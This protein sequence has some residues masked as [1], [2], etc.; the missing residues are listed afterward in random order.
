M[1]QYFELGDETLWNPSNGAAR[2]FLRQVAVFEAELGLPSGIGPMEN[3]ESAIDPA[4]LE[5]FATALLQRR[6]NTH[7]RIM[8]I[9]SEGFTVT[10]LALAEQ[11]HLD[12]PWSTEE[13]D[14]LRQQVRRVR[15]F[16]PT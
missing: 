13:E 10:L 11:A 1:S 4:A 15:G 9:L 8:W 6:R 16:M 2:L 3:D 7:H 12:L 14:T 5:A